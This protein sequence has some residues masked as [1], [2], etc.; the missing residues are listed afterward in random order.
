MAVINVE[1]FK[2]F[3]DQSS[4][5]TLILESDRINDSLLYMEKRGIK[6]LFLS[7]FHDYHLKD[8]H[9]LEKCPYLSY[10]SI[11]EDVTDISGLYFLSTLKEMNLEGEK[12]KLDFSKFLFLEKLIITWSPHLNNLTSCKDLSSLAIFKYK[13]ISQSFKEL[14]ELTWLKELEISQSNIISFSGLEKFNK[15]TRIEFN[16]CSKLKKLCD[17]E[18]TA[19]LLEFAMFSKCK[20]IINHEYVRIFKKMRVLAFNDCNSIHSL[21]FIREMPNLKDLRF[22]GTI[23]LD[24]DLSPCVGLE[25][26]G[27]FYKKGYSHT[28][29][30]LNPT[31]KF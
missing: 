19:D 25:Y 4:G 30:Q 7:K 10:I 16:Y 12:R 2:M 29:K 9:F 5:L 24:G 23:I 13:P 22:V 21:S 27:F 3:N 11:S 1:G 6:R 26:V 28:Y 20:S 17:L 14:S 18:K 8:I 15:L 31:A